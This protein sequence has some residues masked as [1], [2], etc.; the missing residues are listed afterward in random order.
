MRTFAKRGGVEPSALLSV[1]RASLL[2]V[3]VDRPLLA[4]IAM[5]LAASPQKQLAPARGSLQSDTKEFLE[6]HFLNCV[7]DL[8]AQSI[9]EARGKIPPGQRLKCSRGCSWD[10]MPRG[11]QLCLAQ[12]GLGATGP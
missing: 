8:T 2:F 3:V 6:A 1:S 5:E 9:E 10:R 11:T 12:D 4:P 7:F